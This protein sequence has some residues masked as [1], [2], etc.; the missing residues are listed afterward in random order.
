[1][2]AIKTDQGREKREMI[3]DWLRDYR[4]QHGYMPSRREL[5]DGL[6]LSVGVLKHHV[7]SLVE[8]GYLKYEP[9]SFRTMRL[10][11]KQRKFL[12]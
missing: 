6:G 1:M 12:E 4:D 3:L 9:G 11:R 7:D 8:Q 10:T 2:G 5:C